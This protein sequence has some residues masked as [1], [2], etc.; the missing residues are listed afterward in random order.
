M[1]QEK[2]GHDIFM[3]DGVNQRYDYFGNI[4]YSYF[5]TLTKSLTVNSTFIVMKKKEDSKYI[6]YISDI[7]L[8]LIKIINSTNKS[9]T[10]WSIFNKEANEHKSKEEITLKYKEGPL[11]EKGNN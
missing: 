1:L 6:K 10:M 7:K 11:I 5:R 4:L 8:L 3:S 9:K 2:F